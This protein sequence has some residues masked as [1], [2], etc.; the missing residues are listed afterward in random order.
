MDPYTIRYIFTIAFI[1]YVLPLLVYCWRAMQGNKNNSNF[2][3]V[4]LIINA[5]AYVLL[6]YNSGHHAMNVVVEQ[7][8]TT[9]KLHDID[10]ATTPANIGY[11]LFALST[12]ILIYNK[13]AAGDYNSTFY[14]YCAIVIA[15]LLLCTRNNIGI[16][17]ICVCYICLIINHVDTTPQYIIET[18]S[19][20]GL[21]V[22]YGMYVYRHM[23]NNK[24]TR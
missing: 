18:L 19:K 5:C 6:A 11:F 2:F 14:I 16:Y 9:V 13:T 1:S 20:C 3:W 15:N 22:Y 17:L 8:E 12:I 23:S 10:Y 24:K 21:L 7:E 4:T